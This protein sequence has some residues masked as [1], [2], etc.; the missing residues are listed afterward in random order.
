MI[1]I[2]CGIISVCIGVT[3]FKCLF[4][5]I[6]YTLYTCE[7]PSYENAFYLYFRVSVALDI[8]TDALSKWMSLFLNLSFCD[9]MQPHARKA[10]ILPYLLALSSLFSTCLP[11][12]DRSGQNSYYPFRLELTYLCEVIGFPVWLL[13]GIRIT[14]RKKIALGAI[15][16]LVGFTIV[17]TILSKRPPFFSYSFLT[18]K[19]ASQFHRNTPC[20]QYNRT[21]HLLTCHFKQEA[22]FSLKSSR[23][24]PPARLS[25]SHGC[26][27]GSISNFA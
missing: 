26:G 2:A 1:V 22:L 3:T 13:W 12:G 15:F 16:S 24:Q 20:H 27:S 17:A 9:P 23:Q 7:T 19:P 4:S 14:L 5:G 8:I 21:R 11:K 6:E 18:L 25:I 10:R